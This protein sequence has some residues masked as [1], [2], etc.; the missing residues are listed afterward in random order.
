MQVLLTAIKDADDEGCT[1]LLPEVTARLVIL[2]AESEPETA[3]KHFE[4]FDWVAGSHIGHPREG[5]LRLL[6]RS[7]IRAGQGQLD[8]AAAAAANAA[9]IAEDSGLLLL[10]SEAYLA[11]AQHLFAGG[12]APGARLATAS[13]ARCLR[14]AG[15]AG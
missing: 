10:A 6:A 2:R 14:A 4:L 3:L 1:L 7:A 12:W 13:A 8:R 5:Y 15:T 9:R 11:Q